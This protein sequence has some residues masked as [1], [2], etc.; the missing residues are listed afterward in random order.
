MIAYFDCFSG[1]SGDMTLGA[2]VDLGVPVDWLKEQVALIPLTG[3]DITEE[4][5]ARNGIKAKLIDVKVEEGQPRRD[6]HQIK[7]LIENCPFSDNVKNLGLRIFD[8]IATAEAH[9]HNSS[10][11]HVHFHEVGGLDAIVDVMGTALG[12]EFL[13][14]DS[15]MASKIPLGQGLTKSMHGV[16]PVPAPATLEILKNVPT[17]GSGIPFE[18]VTP[19]GAAIITTLAESFG[20]MPEMMM[21]GIGYGSG[22]RVLESQPNL[23]RVVTGNPEKVLPGQ[24]KNCQQDIITIIETSI[25]DMNPEIYGYL[26]ERLQQAGALDVYWVPVYMK[27][28]RPGTLVQV[29]CHPGNLEILS[30]IILS[31]TTSIGLRYYDA[32]RYM[33]KRELIECDTPFGKVT[34]KQITGLDGSV[35]IVPEYEE[36]RKIAQAKGLSIKGVYDAID[37]VN[38]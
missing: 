36:C 25:D 10:K 14:I 31:E 20:P 21:G 8:K 5:V 32:G 13:K 37:K 27:K 6:Y 18:I 4:T 24:K 35:R 16:I 33:L 23:L 29:L 2:L 26:M 7:E 15:V 34:V 9:I 30:D 11:E 17:Y 1:I 19:T 38:H 12:I 3:F 28:N 22:Q